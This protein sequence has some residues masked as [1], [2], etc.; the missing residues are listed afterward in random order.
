MGIGVSPRNFSREL[1]FRL[2]RRNGYNQDLVGQLFMID[3]ITTSTV[4]HELRDFT[5]SAAWDRFVSR[6]RAPVVAF[7]RSIGL[8]DGDADD[9]AQDT[10]I[11]FAEGFRAGRYDP[12]R[13]KLSQ[14]LFGIAY[15]TSLNHRRMAGKRAALTA[16][17]AGDVAEIPMDEATAAVTWDREWAQAL[18]EQC[19]Q[20]VRREVEPTTFR[21]FEMVVR[22]N[23]PAAKVAD[24][25]G[26]NIKLVYNAKHRVLKRIREL[27]DELEQVSAMPT[28]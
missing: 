21:A 28:D 13:G 19:V 23:R 17:D 8:A 4:L 2:P 7:A 11:T 16:K 6:F 14:W 9:V 12:T 1:P 22:E 5:N 20:Q 27:R 18:L 25:L 15:R 10:L 3:W 24:E 26:V